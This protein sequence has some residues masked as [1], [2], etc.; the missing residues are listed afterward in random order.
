MPREPSAADALY[1]HLRS[2]LPERPAQQQKQ[3]SLAA[4]MYPALAPPP[5]IDP[6][7][8]NYLRYMKAVGLVAIE[9]KRR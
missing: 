1:P 4:S 5:P 6:Y 8:E 9:G 7:R 3:P 2:Q